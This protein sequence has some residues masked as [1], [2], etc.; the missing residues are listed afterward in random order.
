[1]RSEEDNNHDKYSVVWLCRT[2]AKAICLVRLKHMQVWNHRVRKHDEAVAWAKVRPGI[3]FVD[4]H[5]G[6]LRALSSPSWNTKTGHHEGLP[7]FGMESPCAP[8]WTRKSTSHGLASTA[9]RASI[10]FCAAVGSI[11]ISTSEHARYDVEKLHICE[12]CQCED[13]GAHWLICPRFQSLR[14]SIP[15]W[16]PDNIQLPD[17]ITHHLL[18]PKLVDMVKWRHALSELEDGEKKICPF[19][20]TEDPNLCSLMGLVAKWITLDGVYS[21]P[22]SV[23]W[24]A[25][26]T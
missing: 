10:G 11:Y 14:F 15:G 1:M 24:L 8:T 19:P 13:D 21:M 12:L 9:K 3:D 2:F 26:D 20:Q 17:R 5:P 4:T 7:R 18:V 25:W 23:Q 6:D 16:F 22:F